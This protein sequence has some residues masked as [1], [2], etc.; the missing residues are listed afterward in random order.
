V[1]GIIGAGAQLSSIRAN[2]RKSVCATR[3]PGHCS[4][5]FSGLREPS[6]PRLRE[7]ARTVRRVRV[8]GDAPMSWKKNSFKKA[9]S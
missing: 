8:I 6:I 4:K 2:R 1:P 9:L 7:D 3:N 5:F